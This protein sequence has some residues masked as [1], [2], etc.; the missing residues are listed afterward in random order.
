MQAHAH[1][2]THSNICTCMHKY[3]FTLQRAFKGFHNLSRFISD[4]KG[5][6]PYSKRRKSGGLQGV[7]LIV[8][9]V[10]LIM[11]AVHGV[12]VVAATALELLVYVSDCDTW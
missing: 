12:G 1:T 11:I 9:I 5:N 6:E 7:N 8:L 4:A 2:R 10:I 3:I